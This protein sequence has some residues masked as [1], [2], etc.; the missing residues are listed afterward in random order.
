MTSQVAK[1]QV[2]QKNCPSTKK[3][4]LRVKRF[5]MLLDGAM[6]WSSCGLSRLG[7]VLFAAVPCLQVVARRACRGL[8]CRHIEPYDPASRSVFSARGPCSGS[9][10][11]VAGGSCRHRAGVMGVCWRL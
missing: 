10:R 3:G 9:L 6:A 7:F 11:R 4:A 8:Q 1:L 2:L 5:Q